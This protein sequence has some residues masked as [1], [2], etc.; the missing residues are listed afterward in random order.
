MRRVDRLSPA[1]ERTAPLFRDPSTGKPLSYE[2]INTWT[3]RF[4]EV[5]GLPMEEASTHT[6]RISGA[7]ALFTAG[8]SEML[9][10][11]MGRWSSDLHRLYVR[12]CYRTCARWGSKIGS[13]EVEPDCEEIDELQYY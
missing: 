11:T 8:G 9:I 3:K 12:C 6:Y 5:L 4:A 7:T 13:A 1:E 10:R 2:C